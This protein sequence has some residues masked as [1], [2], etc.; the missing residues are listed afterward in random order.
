MEHFLVPKEAKDSGRFANV[1]VRQRKKSF[2]QRLMSVR[3]RPKY[4][5]SLKIVIN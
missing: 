3:Q 4:V 5:F 1:S 2:R